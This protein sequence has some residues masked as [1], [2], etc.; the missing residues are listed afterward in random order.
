MLLGAYDD[1][2]AVPRRVLVGG[3]S[4]SGKSHLARRIGTA[5]GVPY[6]EIDALHHGPG[7]A[8]RPEFL[9]D[10]ERLVS[11]ERWVTEW[12]YHQARPLLLGR[13]DLVVWLDLPT[14]TTMRQV[15]GRTLFRW[16]RRVE[17][18]NGNYEEPI[19]RVFTHRD[20][21]IRW[22]WR[23]RH[24]TGER[25]REVVAQRPALPVVHLRSRAEAD[26]WVARLSGNAGRPAPPR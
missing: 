18:W 11:Q 24:L 14:R 26:A 25:V 16:L 19:W 15:T 9:A 17:L 8:P 2:P 4:G 13:C 23:T 5:L 20:H 7:W 6:T 22:A 1:L 3:T 21:I 12:Q 10:V